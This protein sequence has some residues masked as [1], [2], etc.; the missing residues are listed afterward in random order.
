M[1]PKRKAS[2][3]DGG[4]GNK[5]KGDISK[6]VRQTGTKEDSAGEGSSNAKGKIKGKAAAASTSAKGSSA[7]SA[8]TAAGGVPRRNAQGQLVFPD[9]P[10]G[11]NNTSNVFRDSNV[12][13]RRI[14]TATCCREF[15][16]NT[17]Q[18]QHTQ[19]VAQPVLP[20]VPRQYH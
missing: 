13:L 5:A 4:T 6:K 19:G 8:A 9:Y 10:S 12:L 11:Y 3:V 14:T 18:L 17:Q 20:A 15:Y 1:P 7:T 2:D 16:E